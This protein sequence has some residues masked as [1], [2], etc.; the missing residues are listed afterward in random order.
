MLLGYVVNGTGKVQERPNYLLD[1]NDFGIFNLRAIGSFIGI[2]D[3]GT[4]LD[5]CVLVRGVLRLIGIRVEIF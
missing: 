1:T 5:L 3:F 4:I 2:L